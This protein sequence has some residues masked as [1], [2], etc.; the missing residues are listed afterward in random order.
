MLARAA[1]H[2]RNLRTGVMGSVTVGEQTQLWLWDYKCRSGVEKSRTG[3]VTGCWE[4]SFG[5][6][7]QQNHLQ[8]SIRYP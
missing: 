1:A 8:P 6:G 4:V 3:E 7:R 5:L 2:R